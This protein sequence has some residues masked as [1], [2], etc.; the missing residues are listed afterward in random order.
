MKKKYDRGLALGTG[1]STLRNHA[2]SKSMKLLYGNHKTFIETH[3]EFAAKMFTVPI[4]DVTPE[5]R[6]AAKRVRFM[7][8]YSDPS[9]LDNQG[10]CS[11]VTTMDYMSLE[12]RLLAWAKDLKESKTK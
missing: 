1:K 3:E 12:K 4:T 10:T 7:S 11:N 9:M 2:M 5:Q 8:L 6:Q